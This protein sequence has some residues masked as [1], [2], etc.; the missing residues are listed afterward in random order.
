MPHSVSRL[1]CFLVKHGGDDDMAT[2]LSC[3]AQLDEQR[4][5]KSVTLN[6]DGA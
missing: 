1:S 5:I 4:G 2:I 3:R 6:G